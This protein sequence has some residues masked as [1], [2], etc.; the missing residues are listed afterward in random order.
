VARLVRELCEIGVGEEARRH[1]VVTLQELLGA[2]GGAVIDD[3]G[4]GPGMSGRVVFTRVGLE[5]GRP[6]FSAELHDRSVNPCL[7]R[8]IA[9]KDL[10][11]VAVHD[12]ELGP[13]E[14]E[15][16][17]YYNDYLRP[18]RIGR[19]ICSSRVV[20]ARHHREG[21]AFVRG[22]GERPFTEGDTSVLRLVQLEAPRSFEDPSPHL[23]P[24]VRQTLELVLTGLSDKEIAGRL[25]VS[26]HTARQYL[27][28][29]RRA[30][31]VRSRA[32]LIARHAQRRASSSRGERA[33]LRDSE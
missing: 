12:A 7:S 31:G 15:G 19:F 13:R 29:I 22:T 21:F 32:E 20:G 10:P 23:A 6:P 18:A 25:Q 14:W 1:L 27:K 3:H 16:T 33:A 5:D 28:V 11:V 9:A 8:M 17:S 2:G 26:A 4:F 30:Y 24:R